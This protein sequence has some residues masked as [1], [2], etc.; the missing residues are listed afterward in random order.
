MDKMPMTQILKIKGS[1][2]D[3]VN[4]CRAT[5]GKG[6]LGKE[7]SAA[8][9][10]K[11][12]MAEHS[13]IRELHISWAWMS[14]KS[15]IATHWVRHVW[16]CYVKSQRDDR[17]G[18][19]R[20]DLPQAALVDFFGEANPQHTIDTWRKRLCFQASSQ[21]RRYAEDFKEA[22]RDP[23]PEW[24]DTLVPNCVYR[25]GCPE[26]TRC[27]LAQMNKDGLSFW[28]LLAKKTGGAILTADL[29]E[30]YRLYNEV[31]WAGRTGTEEQTE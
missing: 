3:V 16:E 11:V 13:P 27:P 25:G 5:V 22:L 4:R 30:R 20:D 15:W 31:F 10:R 7:P 23:Q 18:I 2:E 1:W 6:E 19:P 17:T 9:K 8:F 21:T 26:M 14:I 29:H 12:L 24:S 28:E